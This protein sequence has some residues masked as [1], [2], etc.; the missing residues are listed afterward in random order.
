[1]KA[2]T[3][4]F[5]D[6]AAFNAAYA[7]AIDS[8][9]LEAWPRF[10]AD[11]C[12]YRIT[13]AENRKAG[14]PAGIVYADSRRM[15]EDRVA[16]LR[17]ANIYESQTYRHVLGLPIVEER[18]DDSCRSRTSFLIAR[19]M[20]TGETSVFA[21]GVYEDRFVRSEGR[22]LLSSRVVVCDSNATDTLIALPL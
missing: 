18:G 1:M 6:L 15:L 4:N 9:S 13:T 3:M 22:L 2:Q 10:F 5:L 16:A 17:M 12:H 19:I 8:G 11:D 21:T 20:G 7:E 14:L